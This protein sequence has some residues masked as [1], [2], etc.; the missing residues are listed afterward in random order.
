MK[1][2]DPYV[3]ST[4]TGNISGVK[5]MATAI[6]NYSASIKSLLSTLNLSSWVLIY[7]I[8]NFRLQS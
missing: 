8:D 1:R 2:V 7:N 3:A 5:P 6:G 4:I